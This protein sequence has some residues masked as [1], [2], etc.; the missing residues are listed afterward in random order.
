MGYTA[1]RRRDEDGTYDD[2][3]PS[4]LVERTDGKCSKLI[5]Q[6]WVR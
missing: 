1:H 3:D 6:N 2:N 5:Q 4:V